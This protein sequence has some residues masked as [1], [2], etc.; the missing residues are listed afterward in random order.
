[1][2]VAILETIMPSGHEVAFDRGFYDEL[3]KQG[4]EPC[5]FVPENYPFQDDY[6]GDVQYIEGGE[7]I[8]YHHAGFFKKIRLSVTRELRRRRWFSSACSIAKEK[9]FDCIVIPTATPRY[10]KTILKCSM[11]SSS[12]PVIVNNQVFSFEKKGRIEQFLKLAAKLERYKNIH[13]AFCTTNHFLKDLKNV[14]YVNPPVY[15]PSLISPKGPY[16]GHEPITIG[17]Y[18]YY[19]DDENT[20]ALLEIFAKASFTTP[21]RVVMQTVTANE[22]DRLSCQEIVKANQDNPRFTFTDAYLKGESWQKAID[23]VD[24]ILAPYAS[25]QFFY[26]YSAMCFNALGFKKTVMLAHTVNPHVLEQFNVGLS[27]NFDDK[28]KLK[29]QVVEFINTYKEKYPVYQSELERACELYSFENVVNGLL[30]PLEGH[31]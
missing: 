16:D 29:E 28:E 30:K 13:I 5:F 3:K 22:K 25:K 27:L 8:S 10:L 14:F 19:R 20:K 31:K 18:G 15:G 23:D 11:R 24:I 7:V 26:S 2:K 6:S 9:G 4:H 17:I 12:V 21:I 1:M